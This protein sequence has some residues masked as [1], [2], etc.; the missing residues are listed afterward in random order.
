ME[1]R[2]ESG[3]IDTARV[4]GTWSKEQ[5]KE[6]RKKKRNKMGVNRGKID[7]EMKCSK[8]CPEYNSERC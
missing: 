5:D 1:N 7:C 6:K 4:T 8:E 3:L 2:T